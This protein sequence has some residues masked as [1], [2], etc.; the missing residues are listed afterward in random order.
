[1]F[2][3]N[4][5]PAERWSI[6]IAVSAPGR[7]IYA[8][9]ERLRREF[10]EWAKLWIENFHVTTIDSVPRSRIW[11]ED[12][13]TDQSW[14]SSAKSH[15]PAQQESLNVIISD[16]KCGTV[17]TVDPSIVQIPKVAARQSKEYLWSPV[18]T[19]RRLSRE[20]IDEVHRRKSH[21]NGTIHNCHFSS[22][23]ISK[24]NPISA[25]SSKTNLKCSWIR[26]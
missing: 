3:W 9:K 12:H 16:P 25:F 1:M 13:G 20:H 6:V 24:L 10:P 7:K 17:L 23:C 19:V 11:L 8:V 4:S 22:S 14:T 5:N 2:L 15:I 21:I 26:C 18:F